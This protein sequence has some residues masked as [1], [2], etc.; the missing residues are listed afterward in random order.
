MDL[1]NEAGDSVSFRLNLGKNNDYGVHAAISE[2]FSQTGS[3]TVDDISI[4]WKQSWRLVKAE[5]EFQLGRHVSP[6]HD[7]QYPDKIAKVYH[8]IAILIEQLKQSINVKST[9]ISLETTSPQR[10]TLN[11]RNAIVE[12][13]F[14]VHQ[15]A[16]ARNSVRKWSKSTR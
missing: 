13:W 10:L 11:T 12:A 1:K 16:R 2:A 5:E 14:P 3:G 15:G 9:K 4:G 8:I 7:A 6:R